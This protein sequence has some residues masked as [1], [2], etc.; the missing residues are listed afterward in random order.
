MEAAYLLFLVFGG[1]ILF[2]VFLY[3]VPVNLWI[4]AII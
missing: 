3:F 2:F 4:T 1:I